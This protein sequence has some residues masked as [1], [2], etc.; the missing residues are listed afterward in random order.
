MTSA[1]PPDFFL[2]GEPAKA[3]NPDFVHVEDLAERSKPGNW[4]IAPH[5]HADLCHL[6]LITNGGGSIRYESDFMDFTAPALL[7][8]PAQTV[9]G[10]SWTERSDGKVLTIAQ[11]QLQQIV[12]QHGEF[13]MLFSHSRCLSLEQD[14]C[15]AIGAAMASLAQ[16]L[17]WVGLGQS[18]ALQAGLLTVLV[19]TARRLQQAESTLKGPQGHHRLVARYRQMVEDRFRQREPVAAYAKALA[20]SETSLREACAASGQS[21]TAIRDQRAILEAQRLLAFSAM[22]VSEI[23][24]QIGIDDPAYFSRFFTRHCGMSPARWRSEQGSRSRQ[25]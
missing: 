22:S 14:A 2:Y 18:A 7:V 8:V 20:V 15:T 19:Q 9:H 12:S 5:K 11:P 25:S 24:E 23:G 4:Q 13:A 1:L 16:E 6:I 21:P 3:A 17:A 10:F